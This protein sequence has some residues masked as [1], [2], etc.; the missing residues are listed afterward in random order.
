MFIRIQAMFSGIFLTIQTEMT[1]QDIKVFLGEQQE[2]RKC[3]VSMV[4]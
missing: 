2:V 4:G 3:N 1:N